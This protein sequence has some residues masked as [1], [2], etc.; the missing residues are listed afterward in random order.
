MQ[1][2]RDKEQTRTE[3]QMDCETDSGMDGNAFRIEE[4]AMRRKA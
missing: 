1:E 2:D 4:M 3:A